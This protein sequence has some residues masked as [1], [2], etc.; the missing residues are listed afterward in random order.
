MRFG[1]VDV[2]NFPSIVFRLG[3]QSIRRR[4]SELL[5]AGR[6][7]IRF[8]VGEEIFS[9]PHPSRPVPGSAQPPVQWVPE[10][11]PEGKAA[12]AWR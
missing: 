12:V 7:W 5:Q 9:P 11:F 4:Y 2:G 3:G 8:S 6:F 10:Q 1:R